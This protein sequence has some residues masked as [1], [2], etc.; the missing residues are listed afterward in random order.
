ML[1]CCLPKSRHNSITSPDI[2]HH[3]V[4]LL[5]KA[6]PTAFELQARVNNPSIIY[7]YPLGVGKGFHLSINFHKVRSTPP[8]ITPQYIG[9]LCT[10]ENHEFMGTS[11]T[12]IH[13]ISYGHNC[14]LGSH[15]ATHLPHSF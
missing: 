11:G 2:H 3:T 7:T 8:A 1:K 12:C 15:R 10:T 9:M 6:S 14:G 4:S 13:I 5:E